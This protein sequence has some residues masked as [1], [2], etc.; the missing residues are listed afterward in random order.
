ME[1]IVDEIECLFYC[2][3]FGLE[4]FDE[5][6]VVEEDSDVFFVIFFG[7]GVSWGLELIWRGEV[8]D[9]WVGMFGWEIFGYKV[10][11]FFLVDMC[12]GEIVMEGFCGGFLVVERK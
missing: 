8:E 10:G 6:G 11:Y 12:V 5:V 7:D 1:M 9:V 2:E 3:N 4:F